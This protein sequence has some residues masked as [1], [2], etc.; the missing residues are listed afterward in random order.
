[1]KTQP[2]DTIG[3]FSKLLAAQFN[4]I[5]VMAV[6]KESSNPE[7]HGANEFYDCAVVFPQKA[8]EDKDSAEKFLRSAGIHNKNV[9]LENSNMA[10]RFEMTMAQAKRVVIRGLKRVATVQNLMSA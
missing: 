2:T 10:F 5:R 3:V 4:A 6:R 1:M 8:F 9:Y 7:W